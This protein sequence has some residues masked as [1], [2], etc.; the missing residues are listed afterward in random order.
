MLDDTRLIVW[1]AENAARTH[2]K[3]RPIPI[4]LQNQNARRSGD[5]SRLEKFIE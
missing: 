3:L 4:G 1:F 5:I 2:P